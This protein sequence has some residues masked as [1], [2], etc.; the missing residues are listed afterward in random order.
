M[1]KYL[2]ETGTDAL[3]MEDGSFLLLE[4]TF[5]GDTAV[6]DA[7]TA[8]LSSAQSEA[9]GWNAQVR[10]VSG[11][12]TWVR[13]SAT[14]ATGTISARPS[15]NI[16]AQETITDTVPGSALAGGSPLV[17]TPTFTV[18]AVGG[19]GGRTFFALGGL[20]GMGMAGAKNFRPGSLN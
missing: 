3:L 5:F 10:D 20:D 14:V 4:G 6:Q 18:A 12:I 17:A 8:G 7:L 16:T 13:T 1:S 11:S 2:L 19:G 9:A 15:Y